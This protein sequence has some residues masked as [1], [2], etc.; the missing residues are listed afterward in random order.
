MYVV[1]VEGISYEL[2]VKA[3][4][5]SLNETS[6]AMHVG[7]NKNLSVATVVPSSAYTNINWS[8]SDEAVA[9]VDNTGK[10]TA[11]GEGNATITATDEVSGCT[12]TCTV[13]VDGTSPNPTA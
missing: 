2:L 8:S 4:S 10:I 12:A 11:N 1:K 13:T 5:I 7:E 3:T 9:V 6:T